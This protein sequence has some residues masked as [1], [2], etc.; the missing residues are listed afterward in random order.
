[1]IGLKWRRGNLI[2]KIM[3]KKNIIIIIL[4]VAVLLVLYLIFKSK[5]VEIDNKN[6]KTSNQVEKVDLE[7]MEKNY[8]KDVKVIIN[9]YLA[10]LKKNDLK[11]E[12]VMIIRDKLLALKLPPKYKDMHLKLVLSASKVVEAGGK[13][14]IIEA[15]KIINELKANYVWLN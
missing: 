3:A 12:E 10:I 14:G 9:D 2:F 13:E 4:A 8:E 1:M 5:P 11:L 6:N 7:Q 15:V